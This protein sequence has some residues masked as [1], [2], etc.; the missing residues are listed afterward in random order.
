MVLWIIL[1]DLSKKNETLG[2]RK[3]KLVQEA[4][5]VSYTKDAAC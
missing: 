3:E 4:D 1:C 5:Y 2:V